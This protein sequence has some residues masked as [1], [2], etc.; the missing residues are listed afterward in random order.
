MGPTD[1][2]FCSLDIFSSYQGY[3][4]LITWQKVPNQVLY[5]L[6]T[7]T[8]DKNAIFT[9]LGRFENCHHQYHVYL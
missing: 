5:L 1:S 8:K 2:T 3:G 4:F 7:T 9:L 6:I